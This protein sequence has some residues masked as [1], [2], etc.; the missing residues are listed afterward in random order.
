MPPLPMRAE[1]EGIDLPEGWEKEGEKFFDMMDT[2]GDGAL[3]KDEIK[4]EG[5][6]AKEAMM[7]EIWEAV[8]TDE[9]GEWSVDEVL[10]A[11][12][13]LAKEFKVELK[14]GW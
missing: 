8:D 13:Y 5:E 12:K 7:A 3:T 11:I 9:D 6:E 1:K 4:E 14:E 10:G 2:N